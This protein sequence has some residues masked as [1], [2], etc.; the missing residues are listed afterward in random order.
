[1]GWYGSCQGYLRI[2]IINRYPW[3]LP[4]H[5]IQL[6]TGYIPP[7]ILLPYKCSIVVVYGMYL[8]TM[9]LVMDRVDMLGKYLVQ[10]PYFVVILT[11][12]DTGIVGID[13]KDTTP[14]VVSRE[15]GKRE[16]Y[17]NIVQY[18]TILVL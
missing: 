11:D 13:R 6:T 3:Q 9:D 7:T 18:L 15:L 1:M 10:S 14:P 12:S 5:T 2:Y 4:Y 16:R 17:C 8:H